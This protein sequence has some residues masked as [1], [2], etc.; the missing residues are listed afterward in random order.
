MSRKGEKRRHGVKKETICRRS[1]WNDRGIR[2]H[3]NGFSANLRCGISPCCEGVLLLWGGPISCKS[4]CDVSEAN[5][6]ASQLAKNMLWM[7]KRICVRIRFRN[8]YAWQS[9]S[10]SWWSIWYA[11]E[12]SKWAIKLF[13][14]STW[15]NL[16]MSDFCPDILRVT[17]AETEGDFFWVFVFCVV[18]PFAC[19][20]V[21]LSLRIPKGTN[22]HSQYK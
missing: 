3:A 18:S 8:D 16:V 4:S 15:N 9:V 14:S 19:C 7:I 12:V 5:Q 11:N 22:R 21:L 2:K 1:F 10:R 13:L 20:L 17:T 6:V